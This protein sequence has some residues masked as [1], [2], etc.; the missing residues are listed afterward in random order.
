METF[1]QPSTVLLSKLKI[2]LF[3]PNPEGGNEG[4]VDGGNGGG[5]WW[6]EG[7]ASLHT[8]AIWCGNVM[9]KR[10]LAF[11]DIEIKQIIIVSFLQ[12][13]ESSKQMPFIVEH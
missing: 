1:R 10:R 11:I 7:E 3:T 8:H 4:G 13:R 6:N 2:H 12:G 5:E 9:H